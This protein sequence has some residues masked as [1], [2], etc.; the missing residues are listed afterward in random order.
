MSSH[1]IPV[2]R[3]KPY[4]SPTPSPRIQNRVV[5]IPDPTTGRQRMTS[6][7]QASKENKLIT[8][9]DRKHRKK[10]S[11]YFDDYPND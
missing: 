2:S 3:P 11:S 5:D 4:I 8:D 6:E 10:K 7:S 1:E 9:E